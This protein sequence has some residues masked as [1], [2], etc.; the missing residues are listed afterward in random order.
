MLDSACCSLEFFVFLTL[1]NISK[2]F[3]TLGKYKLIEFNWENAAE[4]TQ[5]DAKRKTGSDKKQMFL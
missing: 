2:Y 5:Q 3:L 1:C 4:L